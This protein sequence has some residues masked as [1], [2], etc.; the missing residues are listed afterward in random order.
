M[1]A[2]RRS[3]PPKGPCDRAFGAPGYSWCSR[4][5]RAEDDRGAQP[6]CRRSH[7]RSRSD[8]RDRR[9]SALWPV[10]PA[11]AA[12]AAGE[13]KPAAVPRRQPPAARWPDVRPTPRRAF[14]SQP[15]YLGLQG[16]DLAFVP[17]F[18][19]LNLGFQPLQRRRIVGARGCSGAANDARRDQDGERVPRQST[20]CGD[21]AANSRM[22]RNPRNLKQDRE[23]KITTKRAVKSGLKPIAIRRQATTECFIRRAAQNSF[24]M[25]NS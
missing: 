5:Y 13:V 12:P 19:L 10:S 18:E 24:L 8:S 22:H 17:V 3:I 15:P 2:R 4:R 7:P 20:T 6:Y 9:S 11:A 16:F 25:K 21:V 23:I 1:R 14:P